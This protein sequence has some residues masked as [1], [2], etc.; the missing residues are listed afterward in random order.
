MSD[1]LDF[2]DGDG[3]AEPQVVSEAPQ[4]EPEAPKAEGPARGPDG[5]FAPKSEPV[6]EPDPQPQ[7]AQPEPVPAQPK[8]EQPPPGY[9][10]V[11]VVQEL[12][13]EIKA[14]KQPAQQPQAPPDRYADPEGYEAYRE[15]LLQ[16]QLIN[17]RLDLSE[18]MARATHGNELVDAARDWA[19]Q[20]FQTSPAYQAEVLS[21][22]NPYGYVVA[23]YQREQ[24]ISQVT[25]DEFAAYQAWKQAQAQVQAAAPS[26]QPPPTPPRSLASATAAGGSKP[27]DMPTHEGAAFEA[28]FKG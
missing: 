17:T 6:S 8:A 14:L 20:K 19:V 11:S 13:Q 21:Q 26:P 22:R 4:A 12:R 18:E 24:M 1:N 5:K 27:G 3:P 10:P 25:P 16:D 2:L 15:Q 9:V 23:Q 28:I 7:A